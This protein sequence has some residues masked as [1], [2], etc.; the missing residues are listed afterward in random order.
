[1][2]ISNISPALSLEVYI[3]RDDIPDPTTPTT[4]DKYATLQPPGG[5]LSLSIHDVPPLVAGRY[6]ILVHNPNGTQ[7]C[8]K[9]KGVVTRNL[10][11][12]ITRVYSSSN[13]LEVLPDQSR[14]FNAV[15]VEENRPVTDVQ[16]G[17]RVDHGRESDLAVRLTDP[18]GASTVL[19]ENRGGGDGTGLGT[20]T[21]YTNGSFSH[22]ALVFQRSSHLASLYVNAQLVDQ[23]VLPRYNPKTTNDFFFHFDPSG[24]LGGTNVPLIVDDFGIWGTPIP[25]DLLDDI[26]FDGLFGFGKDPTDPYLGLLSWWTFDADGNDAVGTNTVSFFGDTRIVPGQIGNAIQFNTPEAFGRALASPTLDVGS[27]PGFT[28][29]GWINVSAIP[30]LIAGWGNTNDSVHPALLANY[31]LP[32]GSGIGSVSALLE[33]DLTNSTPELVVLKSRYGVNTVGSV[34]TNILYAI[35]GDDVASANQMI[36]FATPP[37]FSDTTVTIVS[38]SEFETDPEGSYTVGSILDGWTVDGQASQLYT[39][40][41]AYNGIGF[42]SLEQLGLQRAVDVAKDEAYSISFAAKRSPDVTNGASQAVVLVGTNEIG[43]LDLDVFWQTNSFHYF[44]KN[45]ESV[46]V[47]IE[48][49]L[50]SGGTNAGVWL[51]SLVVSDG[52]TGHYLPEEPLAPHLGVNAIGNWKLEFQDTRGPIRGALVDWQLTLTLAPTNPAAIRLTNGLAFQTNVAGDGTQYFIVEVPPEATAATNTLVSI[53]GGPLRLLF[54]QDGLPDGTLPNDTVLLDNVTGTGLQVLDK[55]TLPTLQP[56]RRYYL[57]V[58]NDTLTQSNVF[59]V[60]VDLAIPITPLQ[61]GVPFAAT[62]ADVGLMDYYSFDVAPGVLA[63]QFSVSNFTSDVNLVLSKGQPLPTRSSYQFSSTN[64]GTTPETII[65]DLTDQPVPISPGRWYL[66]VYATGVAAPAPVPYTIVASQITNAVVLANEV[67]LKST[68][69]GTNGYFSLAVPFNP[70]LIVFALQ[71]LSAPADLFV[72]LNDVPLPQIGRFDALSVADD[73][74]D[75]VVQVDSNT[76]PVAVAGGT[77]YVEV[78][79]RGPGPVSFTLTALYTTSD[80]PYTDLIDSVPTYSIITAD[81][82]SDL[83]RFVAPTNTSGLLFELYGMSGEAHLLAALGQFPALSTNPISNFQS[84]GSP[85]SLVLRTNETTPDI[86]GTYFLEVRTAGGVDA[87]YTIR[88]S[89]RKN[90]YLLSGQEFAPTFGDTTADGQ[91]TSLTVNVV[92]TE[93]YELEY[94]AQLSLNPTNFIWTPVPPPIVMTNELYKFILPPSPGF[95]GDPLFFRVVHLPQP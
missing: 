36:K 40:G 92:P 4:S 55:I 7:V 77:W 38:V 8:Y 71:D 24:K 32:A 70:R 26:Y 20:T 78:V 83:Y 22:V 18:A 76:V 66:G 14:A 73:L 25:T 31:P 59:Q 67:P 75:R 93:L 57:G 50:D 54:N 16:V 74:R 23:K 91:P 43:R 35:F 11:S 29:E 9:I 86:S 79:P 84:P 53:S 90:G 12:K 45:A 68:L 41:G 28:L 17:L 82:T 13:I 63:A 65:L 15:T 47:H 10:A 89:T 58:Q 80:A 46:Q 33:G 19:F 3:K 61:D 27:L 88:A 94:S 87:Q 34:T 37:F 30:E 52:G 51:D 56:G 5:T 64:L 72:R 85:E 6:F 62:N 21:L 48:P 95:P 81:R 60:Q 69:N 42:V 49:S 44:S 39:P 2:V 1:M